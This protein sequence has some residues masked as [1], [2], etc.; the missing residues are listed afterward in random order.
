MK[1]KDLFNVICDDNYYRVEDYYGEDI[2][3]IKEYLE[4]EVTNVSADFDYVWQT[5]ILVITIE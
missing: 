2:D 4:N 1:L 5:P 3:N